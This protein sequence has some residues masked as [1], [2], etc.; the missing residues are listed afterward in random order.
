MP[1]RIEVMRN[2]DAGEAI[3]GLQHVAG[4]VQPD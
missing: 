2:L 3:L 1:E 4:L